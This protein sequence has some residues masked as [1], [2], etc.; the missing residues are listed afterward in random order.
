M[1]KYYFRPGYGTSE[2]LIELFYGAE[3]ND[4]ISDLLTAISELKPEV[5]DII[6]LWMNDETLLNINS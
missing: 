6:D 4:F 3:N 2:L 1:Y 5:I